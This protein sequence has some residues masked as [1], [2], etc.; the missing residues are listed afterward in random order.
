MSQIMTI[1]DLVSCY[2]QIFRVI[3]GTGICLN[4]HLKIG[5]MSLYYVD[6]IE[7]FTDDKLS[8]L[9]LVN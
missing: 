5:K 8:Q 1:I 4:C 7:S 6:Q 9:N 3:I 2:V